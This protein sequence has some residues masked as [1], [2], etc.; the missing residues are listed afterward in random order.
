MLSSQQSSKWM[1]T[2]TLRRRVWEDYEKSFLGWHLLQRS[3]WA[4]AARRDVGSTFHGLCIALSIFM[5]EHLLI[6]DCFSLG[7]CCWN[8]CAQA[9]G[10]GSSR[11]TT[12]MT[13]CCRAGGGF[14]VLGRGKS[15]RFRLGTRF[16]LQST[17]RP[18]RTEIKAGIGGVV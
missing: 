1:S 11:F 4:G 14:G 18:G 10:S 13:V 9:Y 16:L 8:L 5:K 3:H 12:A 17:S 6:A 15:S 2:G 7:T